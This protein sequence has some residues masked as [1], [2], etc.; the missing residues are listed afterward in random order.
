[1]RRPAIVSLA[2]TLVILALVGAAPAFIGAQDDDGAG[3]EF[4]FI[5]G[6]GQ[7]GGAGEELQLYRFRFAPD[8]GVPEQS[9]PEPLMIYI[10]SGT[11]GLRL[12]PTGRGT[13]IVFPPPDQPVRFW[14]GGTC[15]HACS[16][17]YDRQYPDGRVAEIPAGSTIFQSAGAVC[18]LCN[19]SDGEAGQLQVSVLAPLGVTDR[20]I[21]FS[22]TQLA[23]ANQGDARAGAPLRA[24]WGDLIV[25]CRGRL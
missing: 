13:I 17:A 1:M 15:D 25:G 6:A 23:G 14:D 18:I 9:Y 3:L 8:S 22:W 20:S 19:L 7:R 16:L 4:R 11:F 10:E 21:A 12:N 2:L 5:D 24:A